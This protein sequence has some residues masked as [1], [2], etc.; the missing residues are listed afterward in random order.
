MPPTQP[1]PISP[2]DARALY[3]SLLRFVRPIATRMK[4]DPEELV[5]VAY[6]TLHTSIARWSP[7]RGC[8]LHTWLN[9]GSNRKRMW[10][11]A[12]NLLYPT[13]LLPCA[14]RRQEPPEIKEADPRLARIETYLGFEVT[15][16]LA[17]GLSKKHVAHA[18]G[19]LPSTF[20]E[21]LRRMR[22]I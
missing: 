13:P 2:R 17:G 8:T 3:L 10:A 1:S 9:T 22:N 11:A 20:N 15:R 5:G 4:C 7:E 18:L 16:A 21:R 14:P 19:V 12:R 6:E